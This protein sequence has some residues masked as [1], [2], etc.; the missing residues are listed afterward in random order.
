MEDETSTVAPPPLDIKAK[1]ALM[2][3]A[4]NK[5]REPTAKEIVDTL[6]PLARRI[7]VP[8]TIGDEVISEGRM[9]RLCPKGKLCIFNRDRY[10]HDGLQIGETSF[11]ENSGYSNAKSHLMSCC[12][13]QN[14]EQML[15]AYWI[16]KVSG[17]TSKKQSVL[18]GYFPAPS[19]GAAVKPVH[20]MHAKDHELFSFVEM[21]V[22]ENWP[23]SSVENELYRRNMKHTHKFSMKTVREVILAMTLGVEKILATEMKEAGMG[24]IVHDGWTKRGTHYFA[25]FATYK[26]TRTIYSDGVFNKVT[27]TVVSLLSVSPLHDKAHDEESQNSFDMDDDDVV[28]EAAEFSARTH[29]VHIVDIL[30][31][32]Y[33]IDPKTWITNQ[34]ADSASVN[35]KLAQLLDIP[36]INCVSHLLNNELKKWMENSNTATVPNNAT[37]S[38]GPGT[39]CRLVHES[40]KSLRSNINAALLRIETHLGPTLQNDTRWSSAHAVMAKW[41]KIEDHA[42][43]ASI[44]PKSTIE[45]PPTSIIFKRAAKNTKLMLDDINAVVLLLQERVLSYAE[46]RALLDELMYESECNSKISTS[47]WHGNQ[48]STEYIAPNSS[49]ITS[50]HFASAVLKMQRRQMAALTAVERLAISKWLKS[51][52]ALPRSNNMDRTVSLAERLKHKTKKDKGEKRTVDGVAVGELSQDSCLDHVIGSAAE[53]ERLWSE[54]RWIL[55]DNRSK[56]APILVEAILFLRYHR[57]LWDENS[58]MEARHAVKEA[59]RLT[60]EEKKTTELSQRL[61]AAEAQ[62]ENINNTDNVDATNEEE[63]LLW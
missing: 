42:A 32:F 40:M 12:F 61:E 9:V 1:A 14:E 31:N 29:K 55:T 10:P 53:V 60:R 16:A 4:S 62:Q 18:R 34:T 39:V 15:E 27:G 5:G 47:H 37:R 45:L 36:H 33:H 6:F 23:L 49:K 26:A 24:S 54:A 35:I 46:C 58:V 3:A 20:I 13:A 52:T 56:T 51:N 19:G 22:M 25:L 48:L 44:E 28:E 63:P 17:P 59:A 8:K 41:E 38:F 50:P 30:Q 21:I 7:K 57:G 11:K 2:R 43:A